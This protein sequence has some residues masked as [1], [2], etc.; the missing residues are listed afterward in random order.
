MRARTVPR[1]TTLKAL[2]ALGMMTGLGLFGV[3]GTTVATAA[4]ANVAARQPHLVAMPY[5][6]KVPKAVPIPTK[7]EF[8]CNGDSPVEAPTRA[9]ICTDIRGDIG[10]DN[11]NTWGGRF[12]DNGVYIGHDEPDMTF[13][14]AA[15]GSGNNVTW[16]ETLPVD[17]NGTPGTSDPGK[18]IADWYELTPAPW[19]SMAMC[20]PYS[21]PQMPCI[22]DSDSNAP[23]CPAA[24]HCPNNSYPGAGSAVMEMQLYPPGNPPFVDSESCSNVGWCAAITIDSLEC[25]NLY[26]TC[27]TGCEEPVN[28][29]FI[30]TNGEPTGPAGP[31]DADFDTNVPNADT[32]IMKPG[33]R[34]SIHMYDAPAPKVAG[35]MGGADAFKVVIDDL[36]QHISGFM[37]ASAANGFQYI[38]M[39]CNTALA[40]WQPE[41]NT[42]S[43]GNIIPWAALQTD[44]STEYET[45]HFEPCSSVTGRVTNPADADDTGGAYTTCVGGYE[46]ND[47]EGDETSDELCYPAND[48]HTGWDGGTGTAAGPPIAS[49]QDNWQQNGD[50]DFDG[51]PYRTEWPTGTKP[52]SIYP[53]SFVESLPSSNGSQYSQWYFQTDIALS[54]STCQGATV[55]S[56]GTVTFAGCSVPPQGSEVEQ[57]GHKAFYPYWSETDTNGTCTIEFGNVSSGAGVDDFREDAQYGTNQFPRFGYP[58][59]EGKIYDNTCNAYPSQGYYL[60]GEGG[61][62]VAAGDAPALPSVHGLQGD[63]VGIAATPDGKGYFAVSNTGAVYT[64]GDAAFAGDLTS[65]SPAV[66]VS[67]IVAIAPTT[68]SG[69][70]WLIGADGGEFA[71]GDAKFHG[72]L[73]GIGI[74]VSD[75]IGMVATPG[76][77]GYL[78]V[79]SD[80]GVFAFGQTRFF[81]SLPGIGVKVSD[82]RGILPAAAGTGYI[83]V[84]SD[85]GAFSFGNGAPFH[86]SLPGEGVTVSDI[87]GIALTSDDGGYWMAGSN[88][89][90]YPFGDARTLKSNFSSS[91]MPI[92]GIAGVTTDVVNA[93]N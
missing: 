49:C 67:N 89:V 72:S 7:G 63:I 64:E 57:P 47:N 44:I 55:P 80:G 14:S 5:A 76:G 12:Y 51:T 32:L 34:I 93:V 36:T 66:K 91:D 33:D 9:E 81:G 35:A 73:P 69:G 39:D 62:V 16:D 71:F 68:D 54:E 50:L 23:S 6:T 41:Y 77:G 61:A 65:L 42:A 84:G 38:D 8:D 56:T 90:V 27:Q 31:G 1:R 79:G 59:V 25:T 92:S 40:N 53:S 46:G 24:F 4:T 22:P 29:A 17:P 82:I 43:D 60:A 3:A 15:A 74:R 2:M 45:G 10:V 70:Y 20:D 30:Q 58:E 78:I 83:L 86:G 21:Y 19:F 37:Q 26:A 88:G 52:T 28:F 75:V 48:Q 11:S 18:D 13:L 87:V 85:G